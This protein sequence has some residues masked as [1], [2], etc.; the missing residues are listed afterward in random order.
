MGTERSPVGYSWA[1]AS[2]VMMS[3]IF[4]SRLL[5]LF[6]DTVIA[7]RFGQNALTDAYRAA[8]QL[9][10]LLF[11]MVAGGALSSALMPVFSRYWENN[12]KDEA[13]RVFST[14]ATIMVSLTLG[15]VVLLE[16]LT[17]P[18]IR[19]MFPGFDPLRHELT[20]SLTRIV[21]PTQV[22]FLMGGLMMATLYARKQFTVPALGP[23]IYNLGIIFGGLVLALS[24]I[25]I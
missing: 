6:R 10:D 15:L 23:N 21:L 1:R 22:F 8:F 3:A 12:Q 25:H 7:Y 14:V 18:A 19:L 17:V 5:G 24:L 4:A 9:P 13:W 16:A 20:V 11:F 2:M